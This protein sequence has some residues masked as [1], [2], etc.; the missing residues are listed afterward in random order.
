MPL[1]MFELNFLVLLSV[2]SSLY[3]EFTMAHSFK[4]LTV[5]I[6]Q[7][8]LMSTVFCGMNTKLIVHLVGQIRSY[9]EMDHG[10]QT[11]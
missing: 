11:V 7:Y 8:Y 9:L 6:Y 2:F 1:L 10:P 3:M 5:S 4:T